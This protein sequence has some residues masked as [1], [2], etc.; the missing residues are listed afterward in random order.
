MP[1]WRA[2]RLRTWFAALCVALVAVLVAQT[3][4]TLVDQAKHD[5]GVAHMADARAGQVLLH[6]DLD[7]GDHDHGHDH[8]S[9][10]ADD[11]VDGDG[12]PVSHHHLADTPHLWLAAVG[13]TTPV[14]SLKHALAPPMA[15]RAPVSRIFGLDRP[16]RPSLERTA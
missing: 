11:A 8:T 2:A 15:G 3:P 16:P 4:V 14:R 7:D 12:G 9:S 13:D 10:F 5:R 1:L 6:M